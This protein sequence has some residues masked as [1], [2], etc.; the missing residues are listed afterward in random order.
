MKLGTC[1]AIMGLLAGAGCGRKWVPDPPGTGGV[2]NDQGPSK[3]D[4]GQNP[5]PNDDMKGPGDDQDMGQDS[6][7]GQ[8]PDMAQT[9]DMKPPSDCKY[10]TSGIGKKVGSVLSPDYT[11][12]CLAP[13]QDTF[14]PATSKEL[15][16]C[17]GTQGINAILLDASASNCGP[18]QQLSSGLQQEYTSQKYGELGVRVMVLLAHDYSSLSMGSESDVKNW[19]D[20]YNLGSDIW[21]CRA[22]S[23][24]VIYKTGVPTTS[25]VDPRTMK[26]TYIDNGYD[27][28]DLTSL[29]KQ[30]KK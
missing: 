26:I 2:G 11:W 27:P 20:R 23:S 15:F 22:D 21:V 13:G 24:G 7:M 8:T 30:N 3:M 28:S 14:A 6:D 19:R 25:I 12:S 17:D 4:M 9:P 16:D 18:C 29:A 1:I 5:P 10:P